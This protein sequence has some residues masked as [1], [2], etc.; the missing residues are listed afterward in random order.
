MTCRL[1]Y[2]ALAVGAG[3]LHMSP[4]AMVEQLGCCQV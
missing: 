1:A 4:Q 3:A 2:P